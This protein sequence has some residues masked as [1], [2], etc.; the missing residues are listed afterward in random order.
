MSEAVV[1]IE[2]REHPRLA[3]AILRAEVEYGGAR[4]LGYLMNVSLGGA[5]LVVDDPPMLES[6]VAFWVLLPWGMGECR[7]EARA[8]WA[9]T[10]E[11]NRAIGA[12]VSFV[13]LSE[14]SRRKLR[15]YLD[16]F[17]ELAAEITS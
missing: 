6:K 16:R 8:V 13:D 15:S 14:D 7:L 17:V 12:G 9:Q 4:R 1:A 10:D 3:P 11:Q 2:Q 5:F